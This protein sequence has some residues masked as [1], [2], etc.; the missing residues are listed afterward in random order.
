[1][2]ASSKQNRKTLYGVFAGRPTDFAIRVARSQLREARDLSSL[3]ADAVRVEQLVLPTL[4]SLYYHCCLCAGAICVAT[5]VS[6]G[7]QRGAARH[8]GETDGDAQTHEHITL[9]RQQC[10]V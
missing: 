7:A 5:S 1:M 3:H 9:A 4:F 2:T 10:C 8:T 6:C